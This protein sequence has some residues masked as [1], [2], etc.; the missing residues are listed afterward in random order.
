MPQVNIQL[1]NENFRNMKVTEDIKKKKLS[2]KKFIF[3]SGLV[4]M[5][6][7]GLVKI[8]MKI[9]GRKEREKF[10]GHGKEEFKFESNPESVKRKV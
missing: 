9:F 10:F 5:G 1:K 7:Y 2:R 4:L 8:P 3:Y 6:I